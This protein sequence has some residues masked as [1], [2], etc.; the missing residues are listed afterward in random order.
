MVVVILTVIGRV[1]IFAHG[2]G[3]NNDTPQALLRG[4]AL[5]LQLMVIIGRRD[6]FEGRSG[7]V[8]HRRHIIFILHI[9]VCPR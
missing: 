6:T 9:V 1:D 8:R 4:G 2:A 5:G 7:R 3:P